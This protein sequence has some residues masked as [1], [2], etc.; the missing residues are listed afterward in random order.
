MWNDELA[1]V[2]Q[3]YA[4]QCTLEQNDNR[5]SQQ[6]SFESVGENF[7]A[8]SLANVTASEYVAFVTAWYNENADYNYEANTCTAVCEHYTQVMVASSITG[9]AVISSS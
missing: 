2:A 1:Q 4:E 8:T 7:A 9:H 3:N 6:S 5:V